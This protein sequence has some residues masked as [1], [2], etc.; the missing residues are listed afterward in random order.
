[1]LQRML[2]YVNLKTEQLLA[3]TTPVS[4]KFICVA[5]HISSMPLAIASLPRE[6]DLFALCA[7]ELSIG[8]DHP[9]VRYLGLRQALGKRR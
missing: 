9:H 2:A 4:R 7:E 3:D 1:M 8:L 6:R 5:W